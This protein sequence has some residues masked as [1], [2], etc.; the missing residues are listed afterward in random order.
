MDVCKTDVRTIIKYLGDAA[1]LYDR[2]RGQR[3]VCRAHM[4]RQLINKL[5]NKLIKDEKDNIAYSGNAH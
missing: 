4:L 1:V 2:Q 5:N 3:Y